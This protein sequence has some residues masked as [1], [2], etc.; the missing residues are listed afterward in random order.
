MCYFLKLRY[1]IKQ[2][3]RLSRVVTVV[4]HGHGYLADYGLGWIGSKKIDQQPTLYQCKR[5]QQVVHGAVA[6][7]VAKSTVRYTW[8][9]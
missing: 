3:Y 5:T 4:G 8:L 7:S 6:K 1:C 2:V 9:H